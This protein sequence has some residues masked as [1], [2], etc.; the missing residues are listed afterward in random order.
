MRSQV[1]G[2]FKPNTDMTIFKITSVDPEATEQGF[3]FVHSQRSSPG[4]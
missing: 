2:T 4:K 3:G 1:A